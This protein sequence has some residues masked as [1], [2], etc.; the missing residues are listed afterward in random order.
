M[1]V[2]LLLNYA[3]CKYVLFVGESVNLFTKFC[4]YNHLISFLLK[5]S[6]GGCYRFVLE[7]C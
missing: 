4:L 5:K 3:T 7:C 1:S 6:K 2:S